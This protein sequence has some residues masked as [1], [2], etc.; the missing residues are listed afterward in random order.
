M[1]YTILYNTY[2]IGVLLFG[3]LLSFAFAAVPFTGK[4]RFVMA[5]LFTLCG[6]GQLVSYIFLPESVIWK[7]Y[8]LLVHL[9]LVLVLYL[10]CKKSIFTIAASVTT[11]YMCCQLPKWVM[12]LL[13]AVTGRPVLGTIGGIMGLL[14]VGYVLIG[15]FAHYTSEI[16]SKEPKSVLIFSSVP[17]V[18]YIFD[19][20]MAVYTN[21]IPSRNLV[22]VEFMPFFLCII[23]FLFCT[24]YYKE[25]EQKSIAL[26][27]ENIIRIALDQQKKEAEAVKRSEKEIRMLRHD[28]RHFLDILSFSLSENDV[29][30]AVKIIENLKS[31]A[32][33]TVVK[34]Y[35]TNEMVNYIISS[36][37]SKCSE[38]GIRLEPV[39]QFENI[40][41]DE[42]LFSSVLSNALENALNAVEELDKKNRFIKLMLKT[43]GTKILLSIKNPYR[44]KPVIVDGM[45]VSRKSGH[46]Y[47]TQSIRFLTEKAGGNCQF[48]IQDELFTL[49]IVI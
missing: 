43:S 6:F 9:P 45:P 14:A 30:S 8:P 33:S 5:A 25:V 18:Y 34:H 46:G 3:I 32:D 27:K 12:I 28:M 22:A 21:L 23:F 36:Y 38:M 11:A 20:S 17:M 37:D 4:N 48:S 24:L 7:L 41:I 26:Q 13:E 35:C 39:I 42:I 19:Y 44:E 10:V 15:W 29:E 31:T 2:Y 47:G 16:F 49:R 1:M 40:D